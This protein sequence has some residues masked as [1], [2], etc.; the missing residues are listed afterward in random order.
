MWHYVD[1]KT[2]CFDCGTWLQLAFHPDNVR[3]NH[4]EN[5]P[6]TAVRLAY[7]LEIQL[8]NGRFLDE[9]AGDPCGDLRHRLRQNIGMWLSHEVGLVLMVNLHSWAKN[10]GLPAGIRCEGSTCGA[11]WRWMEPHINWRSIANHLAYEMDDEE[12]LRRQSCIGKLSGHRE[13][14]ACDNPF[15]TPAVDLAPKTVVENGKA[16]PCGSQ[17]VTTPTV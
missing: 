3:P 2:V 16:Q 8:E 6:T 15:Y 17:D 10:N 4:G 12:S 7:E 1:P 13:D 5:Y 11:F 9:F 14:L